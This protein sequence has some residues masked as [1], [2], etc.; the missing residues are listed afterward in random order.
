MSLIVSVIIEVC[1]RFFSEIAERMKAKN[2]REPDDSEST[3]QL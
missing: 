1:H 2:S 3:E